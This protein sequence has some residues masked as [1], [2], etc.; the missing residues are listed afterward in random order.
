[1]TPRTA[2]RDQEMFNL[3]KQG[4][5]FQEIADKY[6]IS[7]QRVQQCIKHLD[8]YGTETLNKTRTQAQAQQK[9]NTVD[10]ILETY[11]KEL[12][13]LSKTHTKAQCREIFRNKFPNHN[14]NVFE[15]V[16]EEMKL[17]FNTN[18]CNTRTTTEIDSLT[19]L[20]FIIGYMHQDKDEN[21]D[22]ESILGTDAKKIK[23]R[24][25][26]AIGEKKIINE[27]MYLI[28]YGKKYVESHNNLYITVDKYDTVRKKF[29]ESLQQDAK[30]SSIF[31]PLTSQTVCKRL[32]NRVWND[33]LSAVGISPRRKKV[34][35]DKRNDDIKNR[36][37][38][39]VDEFY[40]ETLKNDTSFTAENYDKWS[41]EMRDAVENRNEYPCISTVYNVYGRWNDVKRE[42][43]QA[44]K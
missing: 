11:G 20:W 14:L 36:V 30:N 17:I 31:W 43:I 18:T 15:R 32:G 44:N 8:G 4:K 3:Y 25:T 41:R 22:I 27:T 35:S 34:F 38:K 16:V 42:V 2:Q 10:H 29:L 19:S 21:I 40:I 26:L 39:S 5:T 28:A 7:R 6:S 13:E 9:K 23:K 33:A 1:M 37:F 24:V 12:Q